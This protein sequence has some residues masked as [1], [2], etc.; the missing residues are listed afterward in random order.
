M[1]GKG[2]EVCELCLGRGRGLGRVL[3]SSFDTPIGTTCVGP[4]PPTI[5]IEV[6][7]V[8]QRAQVA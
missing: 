5:K 4:P 8:Q 2:P 3:F 6:E 1:P 7:G